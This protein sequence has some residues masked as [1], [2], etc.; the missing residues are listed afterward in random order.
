M[1]FAIAALLAG[2]AAKAATITVN[3]HF[4]ESDGSCSDGDCSLSDAIST[5]SPGDTISLSE[6]RYQVYHEIWIS[7]DLTVHGAGARRT[8]LDGNREFVLM[9]NVTE[10][11][12]TVEITDLTIT[13]GN[14]SLG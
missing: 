8:F 1:L 3:V 7:K 2:P 14:S 9:F 4:D 11:N 10:P 5:A 12:A 13:G 6:G